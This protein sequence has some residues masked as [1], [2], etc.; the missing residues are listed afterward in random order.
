MDMELLPTDGADLRAARAGSWLEDT[1]PPSAIRARRVECE[2]S[3]ARTSLVAH[4]P[5]R[6]DDA[7]ILALME[8]LPPCGPAGPISYRVGILDEEGRVYR[9][10]W[11]HCMYEA[12]VFT[13]RMHAHGFRQ[14][15]ARGRDGEYDSAFCK[16]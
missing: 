3:R 13:A 8:G 5:K 14:V 6:Q 2:P 1:S 7:Q 10:V 4:R 15:R 11:L 12:L 9:E 16:P